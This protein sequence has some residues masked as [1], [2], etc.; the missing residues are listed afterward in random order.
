MRERGWDER[1]LKEFDDPQIGIVG[2]GGALWHGTDELYKTPYEL[3]Q[4]RRGDYIS[5]VDDAEVH[6]ARFTGSTGVCVLDGFSLC[7]RRSLLDRSG[8]WKFM[9]DQCDF[10]CYDYAI[11]ALARRYGY[12]I[13]VVGIRCH[14]RGGSSSVRKEESIRKLTS[15]ENYDKSH[16]W[17]YN[18]FRDVMP[19]KV[20]Q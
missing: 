19:C 3:T 16:A 4:L 7:I 1:I 8:G 10:F 18:E 9:A 11:C 13:R 2:F 12:S 14:H 15:Q 5:N 17:F 20:K 6:G